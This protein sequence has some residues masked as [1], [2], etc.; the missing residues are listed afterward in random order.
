ME[1]KGAGEQKGMDNLP[2]TMTLWMD[3]S[4]HDSCSP[5]PLLLSP[6]K[7][8]MGE[9]GCAMTCLCSL[10]SS[11]PGECCVLPST[12]LP[13]PHVCLMQAASSVRITALWVGS[14]PALLSDHLPKTPLQRS[15]S[16]G[17]QPPWLAGIL[18]RSTMAP[19]PLKF[20]PKD[21]TS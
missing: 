3:N 4:E 13:V 1:L 7:T 12:T 21:A 15:S 16:V 19:R 6:L 2:L 17:Q 14:V 8:N 5:S 9:A 11:D 18:L 20:L 10:L